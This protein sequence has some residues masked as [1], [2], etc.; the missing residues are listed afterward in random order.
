VPTPVAGYARGLA[1]S[2]THNVPAYGFSIVATGGAIAVTAELRDPTVVNGFLYVLG[3]TI[4]FG[5]VGALA[6]LAFEEERV[7]E[8]SPQTVFIGSALS[9][10]STSAGFGAAA[11]VADHVSGGAG[12]FLAAFCATLG[13]VLVL[14]AELEVASRIRSSRR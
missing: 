2:I 12:W 8:A 5:V 6:A 13:Y 4:A 11:L 14:A 7:D 1:M 9:I 10:F 3:A